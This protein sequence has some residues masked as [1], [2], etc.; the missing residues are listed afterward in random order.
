MKFDLNEVSDGKIYGWN[1]MVRV[2]CNDCEGC[3]DCCRDMEDTVKLT[4]YDVYHL[5]KGLQKSFEELLN[6]NIELSVEEGLILPHLKTEGKCSFLN[7]E[8]RCLIHPFRPMVCRLFPLGRIYEDGQVQYIL[9]KGQCAKEKRSKEKVG[10]WIAM[11]DRKA[12]EN[13]A[14]SWYQMR[15][16]VEKLFSEHPNQEF[17]KQVNLLLLNSFYISP[18]DTEKEFYPQYEERFKQV[19]ERIADV[20]GRSTQNNG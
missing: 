12:E 10:K 17:M 8:G 15:K 19:N 5:Q 7:E 1:D 18:Y 9:L 6:E 16:K 13:F 2:G 4:P 11:K 14:L 3:S 20:T